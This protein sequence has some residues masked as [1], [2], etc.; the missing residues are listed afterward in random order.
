MG[1]L[2]ESNLETDLLDWNFQGLILDTHDQNPAQG[3][4]K[5]LIRSST[6]LTH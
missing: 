5:T 6:K 3:Q 2:R 1:V 4:K